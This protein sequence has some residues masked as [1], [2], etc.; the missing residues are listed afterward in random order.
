M[1]I[2]SFL[3]RNRRV[4]DKA[5]DV[6][7]VLHQARSGG[8]LSKVMALA[9]AS[10]IALDVML[11]EKHAWSSM[12]D[13]GLSYK[14]FSNPFSK[15]MA[16]ELL[17]STDYE[18]VRIRES[19]VAYL[20]KVDRT[21]QVGLVVD[22]NDVDLYLGPKGEDVLRELMKC[23][24][25][26]GSELQI[27]REG[28]GARGGDITLDPMRP[29]GPY[30]NSQRRPQ[31]FADRIRRYG[32]GPRTVLLRGPTGVGK[33]VLARHICKELRTGERTLKISSE[34]LRYCSDN[35]VI[36]FVRWLQPSVLVLD[37]M[38]LSSE[39]KTYA[40]LSLL[41]AIR[42]PDCLVIVTMMT[43]P[44]DPEKEP[45]PGSW[46][47]PGMRPGRIDETFTLRLPDDA[48]RSLIMKHYA[49]SRGMMELVHN[50]ALR[51]RIAT[52]AEGLSGAYL[53]ALVERIHVHGMKHWEYE[54]KQLLY[55]APATETSDDS[56]DVPVKG[57]KG[58]K[59]TIVAAK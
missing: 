33:S 27:H 56:S 46:H 40:L 14:Y 25:Q 50:D 38:E 30:V 26:R 6:L 8:P 35:E 31:W 20:W 2:K 29:V 19:Q 41:E 53:A 45:E 54:V 55:T 10:G 17:K 57:Q 36:A 11:P 28:L 52:A 32:R 42:D 58:L 39:S 4:L 49:E 9:K 5:G 12:R 51:L 3:N 43:M 23:V 16:T 24:W 13:L 18:A 21:P 15:F 1:S 7:E 47:F 44:W 34:T 59:G 48:E 37:D 22:T